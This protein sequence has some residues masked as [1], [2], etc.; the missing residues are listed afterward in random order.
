M[1]PKELRSA[2]LYALSGWSPQADIAHCQSMHLADVLDRLLG[3]RWVCD[4]AYQPP[5]S[6]AH[7]D[8]HETWVLS[9]EKSEAS[10]V[11]VPWPEVNAPFSSWRKGERICSWRYKLKMLT[12]PIKVKSFHKIETILSIYCSRKLISLKFSLHD[13][14]NSTDKLYPYRSNTGDCQWM[15]F[16]SQDQWTTSNQ[17]GSSKQSQSWGR[18]DN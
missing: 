14:K 15:Q 17:W 9:W 13:Q 7:S 8:C 1:A 4:T 5:G 2:W 6:D 12:G 16:K 10:Q 18:S 3:G 11:P